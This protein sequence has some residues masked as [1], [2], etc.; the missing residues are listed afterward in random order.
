MNLTLAYDV[1]K[2]FQEN[3]AEGIMMKLRKGKYQQG[4]RSK[5]VVKLKGQVT[6]DGFIT[7]FVPA[8]QEK[9]FK[10]LI[11]GFRISAYVD[12]KVKEIAAVSNIPLEMRKQA[13]VTDEDGNISIAEP[14]SSTRTSYGS[15]CT[16]SPS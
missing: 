6:V 10:G 8:N 11:G 16:S 15:C 3:G 5:E 14:I 7:G 1:V 13:S 2:T 12:G 4:K 9:G